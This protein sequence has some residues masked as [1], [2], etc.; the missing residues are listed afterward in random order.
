MVGLTLGSNCSAVISEE[1]RG[2]L[3]VFGQSAGK[4]LW[5]ALGIIG[6]AQAQRATEPS[7]GV[8]GERKLLR[9][10]RSGSGCPIVSA[11]NLQW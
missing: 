6:R 1:D 9:S 7:G 5:F 8:G 11:G 2:V 10:A 3:S 4:C